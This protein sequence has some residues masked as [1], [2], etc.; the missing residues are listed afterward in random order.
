MKTVYV[1]AGEASGD[2]HAANL[3][4]ALKNETD[5]LRFRGV[6]GDRMAEAGVELFRHIRHTN[7]MGFAEVVAN[8][9]K[10]LRLFRDVRRDAMQCGA[11]AALLV[12]Y[13]GFNLRMAPFFFRRGVAVYYYIA[14]QLWAWKKERIEIFH[15]FVERLYVILPFEPAFFADEGLETEYYGHPILDVE[16]I[17]Q[18]APM[19]ETGP[20]A[21]LPGSR[22]QEVRRHLPV[23]VAAAE[24][25]AR[26]RPVVVAG[27]PSAPVE[28]YR[29][30]LRR[31][32]HVELWH[33]RTYELLNQACAA[34]TASGTA[35]LET[36]LFNVPQTVCYKGGA[37]SYFLAKRWVKVPFISLVN[38]I[39]GKAAVNE[40]IQ[41]QMTPGILGAELETL[42]FD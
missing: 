1:I 9:P 15:R 8:L 12:D 7:F 33:G 38:L 34:L 17:T 4:R 25:F 22:P 10:I 39:L 19:R 2:L 36:A 42:L 3:I 30:L 24:R 27:A 28:L 14:P 40:R 29:S 31:H 11:Q 21:L 13:P 41:S 16:A 18:A 23:M 32:A 26:E 37:I 20:I 6:G 35:T 5:Q